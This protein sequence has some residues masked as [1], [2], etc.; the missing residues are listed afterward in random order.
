MSARAVWQPDAKTLEEARTACAKTA[1]SALGDCFT[2][3]MQKAGASPQAIAF[4]HELHD[5]A[6]LVKFQD[7]GRVSIAWITYPFRANTNSGCLL[8]NGTPRL[9]DVDELSHLP[10]SQLKSDGGWRTLVAKH[11]KAML[12]PGDRSGMSGVS[13]ESL[14]GG[15][16][17]FLVDYMVLDG[18]HACA[19]L[20]QVRYAFD[21][22]TT[23]RLLG[24]RFVDLKPMQ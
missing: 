14:G 13:E 21:F 2:H 15:G 5:D 6:Y 9:V 1:Y 11:P 8:A 18:C 16:Q 4:T 20:A 24:A 19:R 3:Q 23:G 7:T 17:R 22:D 10:L 12:W